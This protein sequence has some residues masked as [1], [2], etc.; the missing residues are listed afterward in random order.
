MKT[1]QN[2][3]RVLGA[4]ACE[5]HRLGQRLVPARR[6]RRSVAFDPTACLRIP[7]VSSVLRPAAA[8]DERLRRLQAERATP[9]PTRRARVHNGLAREGAGKSSAASPETILR[10]DSQARQQSEPAQSRE[11]RTVPAST[12]PVSSSRVPPIAPAQGLRASIDFDPQRSFAENPRAVPRVR[13]VETSHDAESESA[14][15]PAIAPADATPSWFRGES[16]RSPSNAHTAWVAASPQLE[17]PLQRRAFPESPDRS[18]HRS[19]RLAPFHDHAD[20]SAE[21]VTRDGLAEALCDVLR[22]QAALQ[23]IDLP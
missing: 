8:L 12:A 20:R 9:V 16:S 7:D 5:Q 6:A 10:R 13:P 3:R 19:D 1:L 4:A 11:R 14:G 23:G 18:G 21:L 15:P 22:M 2:L 17:R